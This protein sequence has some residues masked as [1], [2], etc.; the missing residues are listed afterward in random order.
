M[1]TSATSPATSPGTSPVVRLDGADN[2][3]VARIEIPKGTFVASEGGTALH[4]VP[5]GHKIATRP[6]R[7]G[8]PVLKYNTVIGF[9]GE[10]LEPGAWMHTHNVLMD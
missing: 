3:A 5:L 6:I 9:A 1:S 8:E 4:D 7:E 2:V 10:D